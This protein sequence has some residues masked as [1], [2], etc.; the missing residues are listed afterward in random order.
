MIVKKI[1]NRP[2]FSQKLKAWQIGDLV[3]YICH[4]QNINPKEKI[5]YAGSREFFSSTHTGHKAE[6]IA[7]AQE[8]CRSKMPVQHWIFSWQEGEQPTADQVEKVVDAF[9]KEMGLEG[10]Q[11]VYGLH[12]NTE[13]FHLHIAVNRVHPET[14]KTVLPHNGFDIE[15]GHRILA[16]VEHE[17]GWRSEENARYTV[18]ENGEVARR[19]CATKKQPCQKAKDFECATGEKS[20]Q[21]IAQEK[22]SAILKTAQRWE[23]VHKQLATLGM[24]Y[25]KVGTSGAVLFVG[26]IAVKASSVGREFSFTAMSKK[27]GEFI[28]A[29]SKQIPEKNVQ[30]QEEIHLKAVRILREATS[31]DMLHQELARDGLK[32]EKKGS[33]ALL[34]WGDIAIKPSSLDR[35]CSLANMC[36]QLGEYKPSEEVKQ[37]ICPTEPVSKVNLEEWKVYTKER[38]EYQEKHT[39]N[40]SNT[41]SSFSLSEHRNTVKKLIEIQKKERESLLK[42]N[43]REKITALN[44][45]RK[46]ISLQHKKEL[47]DLKKNYLPKA[48]GKH[49]E[50]YFPRFETWLR[51]HGENKKAEKWR[52]RLEFEPKAKEEL[53]TLSNWN[54]PKHE[55]NVMNTSL[56]ASSFASYHAAVGADAYR[57]T[58]IKMLENGEKKTFILDKRDGVT[59]GFS[60]EELPGHLPE[61]LRLQAKGENIYYT[62]LSAKK[63]HILIDDMTR[64]KLEKLILDG[65]RPAALL[66]SSPGNYQCILT[67]PKL[68]TP[69][70][71]DVGNRITERLNREYGD[72]KLSGCIHPHRAPGFENRKPKHQKPDGTYPQVSLLKTAPRTCDKA[73]AL[74]QEIDAEYEKIARERESRKQTPRLNL[75]RAGSPVAA[76]QC[77]LENIKQHLTIE[78]ASRVDAM[79]ALRMR[80]TGHSREAV[81]EAIR[82]C[83]TA[84]R[85]ESE[86]RRDWDRYAL[87]TTEY[88]FGLAGDRD[89]QRNE[90]YVEF[91]GKLEGREQPEVRASPRRMRS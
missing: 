78:D 83:A 26:D 59:N 21:R 47:R 57:V 31:W 28:P 9:L 3:D 80:A 70:D 51:Q 53:P 15:A 58:C 12:N 36:K 71:R 54:V 42:G 90:K 30:T 18:L 55:G 74:S 13:N 45:M 72:P 43:W 69:Y 44:T 32:Y 84:L 35:K 88:A 1:K 10:H 5:E 79:I 73:L 63:H 87:R 37:D 8:S 56:E 82:E 39:Q 14:G 49:G 85:G 25:E 46:V 68:G 81:A 41:S 20:A 76:Y 75:G 17:Q 27:L 61:M 19:K 65:F 91:W 67:I 24:R 23:E 34:S 77:H 86:Q 38:H 64:D 22:A 52:Y 2:E 4:P 50:N 89:L 29:V 40:A 33:G 60:P 66:E 16:Q 62:P 48:L 6:M 7:L 11:V